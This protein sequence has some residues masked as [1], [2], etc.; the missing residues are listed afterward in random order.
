MKL[1]EFLINNLYKDDMPKLFEL[2]QNRE[3]LLAFNNNSLVELETSDNLVYIPI[4]SS[5]NE[6]DNIKYTRIDKV[7][8][9]VIIDD[10]FSLNKYH[11]I[12]I[13]PYSDDFIMNRKFID[14][15]NVIAK[16]DVKYT[17]FNYLIF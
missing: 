8:I 17:S 13:N 11:A 14:I 15:Y 10:I 12:T 9:R 2:F 5:E 7:K 6:L 1:K 4:F 3:F 16:K